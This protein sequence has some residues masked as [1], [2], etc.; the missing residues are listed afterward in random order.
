MLSILNNNI[1]EYILNPYLDYLNDIVNLKKL[2]KYNFNMKPHITSNYH[3]LL[4]DLKLI[5]DYGYYDDNQL[6][7]K[8]NLRKNEYNRLVLHGISIFWWPNRKIK[9]KDY[10]IYGKLYKRQLYN[11]NENLIEDVTYKNGTWEY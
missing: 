4:L 11:I 6:S 2:Y 10:F 8:R 7:Y 9:R 5:R 3:H 1:I